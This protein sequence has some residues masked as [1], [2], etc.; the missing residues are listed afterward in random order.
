MTLPFNPLA[1]L[2][3]SA[4]ILARIAGSFIIVYSVFWLCVVLYFS[5]ASNNKELMADSLSRLFDRQVTIGSLHTQWSDFSLLLQIKDLR[6]AGDN[7][8]RAA[9]SMQTLS[10]EL[11]GLSLLMLWPQFNE[12]TVDK[13]T[14][15]IVT[16][17]DGRMQLA[18]I[19]L[20]GRGSQQVNPQRF[21]AWLAEQKS[22]AW[23]DGQVYW[24]QNDGSL[25]HYTD[26]AF[27]YQKQGENRDLKAT[28][29]TDQGVLAFH[30]NAQGDPLESDAWN[31][32][33]ELIGNASERFLE[34]DALSLNVQRGRGELRLKSLDIQRIS[35]FLQ[36]MGLANRTQWLLN[37]QFFGRLHDV[38]FVFSGPLFN[39]KDWSLEAS[40]SEI[41]F[42][43]VGRAPAMNHLEGQLS[44]SPHGGQFSFS[45]E[46]STFEWARWF[47]ASFPIER[48][49]GDF[50]WRY[51]D[52]GDILLE[53]ENGEFSDKSTRIFN[54][55]AAITVDQLSQQIDNLGQLFNVQ[56]VSGFAFALDES[57][58]K[59][60]E[61][62]VVNASAEFAV[63]DIQSLVSYI[64]E[65]P[66][67]EL[68]RNWWRNAFV[69]GQAHNGKASYQGELSTNAMRVGKA[70]LLA[71]LDYDDLI[72]DYGYAQNWPTI[73]RSN[74]SIVLH[75]DLFQLYPKQAW[76][77][78]DKIDTAEV[79]LTSLFSVER[80]VEIQGE[81]TSQLDT[82]LKFILAGPLIK[83]Q[84]RPKVLPV[85]PNGGTITT[86]MKVIVPLSRVNKSIVS[87]TAQVK[88]AGIILPGEVAIDNINADLSYTER[89]VVSDNIR[90]TFLGHPAR[91]VLQTLATTQP[92]KLKLNTRG[93]ANLQALQPW[94]GEHLLTL[95][96]GTTDYQGDVVIDGARIDVS[97][98]SALKGVTLN[99]PAPLQKS[100]DTPKPLKLSMALGD[101]TSLSIHYA[102]S[103]SAQFAANPATNNKGLGL[104]DRSLITL[105]TVPRKT[106]SANHLPEGVNIKLINKELNLDDWLSALL[107]LAEYQPRQPSNNS[108]FLDAMRRIDVVS[109]NSVFF[110][111]NFGAL[112]LSALSV[113]GQYWIGTL[114]GDQV[115][116]TLRA[117][118]RAANSTYQFD[119]NRFN[120]VA[121]P[122]S[123]APPA[124]ADPS[125]LPASYPALSLMVDDFKIDGKPY[126]QLQLKGAPHDD[127][128]QLNKFELEYLG[129]RTSVTG[130]WI[131]NPQVGT[132]S[133]FDFDMN[134]KEAGEALGAIDL[135]GFVNQG[136]GHIKGNLNWIGAPHEFTSA[137]LNGNF[138][139]KI[140]DG[141]LV[142]VSSGSGRLIGLLNFNTIAR[143]LVLDFS[144]V[145]ADGLEFD[146]MVFSGVF[147]DG[148]AIINKAYL[149]APAVFMR[150]EGKVN[151]VEELID[152]EI[153][154]SPELGG[155]LALLSALANPAAGAVVYLTQ[156][157]FKD[158]LRNTQFRSYRVRGTWDDFELVEFDP[159]QELQETQASTT[160]NNTNSV[161]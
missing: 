141:E 157:I 88:N 7:S 136:K 122:T 161:R 143:R 127:R 62:L 52:N 113:D 83:A 97:I 11:R 106:L 79:K 94:T 132:L 98:N 95:M 155:N 49:T 68:F 73:N 67:T 6:V 85:T 158:Q 159:T 77:G 46:N 152:L 4:K 61:P 146:Q 151:L 124:A 25:Q 115:D 15:E 22:A 12:F 80:Q 43:S 123:D 96:Q 75:N 156:R 56:S 21:I 104:F 66:S 142:K 65:H 37:A 8:E 59:T 126:G 105:G 102:D 26:I 108:A 70:K 89:S 138:D 131:N 120:V 114:R 118:P 32:S 153:H 39:L 86:Q 103:L 109:D 10:A 31:A 28:L 71:S 23:V 60:R 100:A 63:S 24:Q 33:F 117:Q 3:Q 64:P 19:A 47:G 16:L 50:A 140:E 78:S 111:R 2:W 54:L 57:Q 44:A 41:G 119:L 42:K 9:L 17:A 149:F 91:S 101:K 74:G 139:L 82:F 130:Q 18:G 116:G 87:G 133:S 137:R 40:A 135:E 20:N 154:L 129:T 14:L 38:R 145:F 144:D 30:S 13:P 45:T 110:G 36:L 48:A 51:Q 76:I 134:I 1:V 69:S 121:Q 29:T 99:A 160:A 107:E 81:L 5:Y 92:P 35:D 125:T 84:N 93:T 128:W 112:S 55:N 148:E 58:T 34:A 90:S 53:L 72:L 27:V 147:A 150:I